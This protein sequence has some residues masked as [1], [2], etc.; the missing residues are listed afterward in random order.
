[1]Y[2]NLKAKIPKIFKFNKFTVNLRK[3]YITR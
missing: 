1:M 2:V 3:Y